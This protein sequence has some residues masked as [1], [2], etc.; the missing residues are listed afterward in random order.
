MNGGKILG[1][2][3]IIV[4]ILS[5][6][7]VG[8]S[9]ITH[10]MDNKQNIV[11]TVDIL[12][13][14]EINQTFPEENS[15]A[16]QTINI[17]LDQKVGGTNI[18]FADNSTTIY[19][20]TSNN[21]KNNKTT[22]TTNKNGT[23]LDVNIDSEDSQNT[24]ILSNK[25]KYTINGDIIAGGFSSDLGNNAQVD[26]ININITAGG[27]D[28]KLNGGQLTTVN[29]QINTGGIN[30]YGEP[31]GV[32]TINSQIEVGGL[33][34][35]AKKQI[36][37]IFSDIKVGGINPGKYQKVGNNEYKGNLFDSS[38]NKLIIHN[39]IRLGGVNTQSF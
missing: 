9:S 25:Y 5:V 20:I 27:V 21:E 14:S 22:V 24:I 6:A 26:A 8:Y 36:A 33:N 17:N 31:K 16:I 3:I 19:N 28:L 23:Q 39:N 37:D 18:K 32:T 38:E 10:K 12:D 34:L 1:I 7:M 35:Q 11:K 30:I 29:S 4:M 13:E 2:L 15:E